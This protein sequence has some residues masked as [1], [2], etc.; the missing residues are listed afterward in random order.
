[1]IQINLTDTGVHAELARLVNAFDNPQPALKSIGELVVEF[2]K[3]RFEVSQ[4]PYGKPW[5]PN[6]DTTLRR[7]LHGNAKNF[8]KVKGRLSARGQLALSSKKPLIGESKSLSTQF[9]WRLVGDGVEIRSTMIYAAM[10]QF[11][12]KKA[13]FPNLWG[14]IPAR[15]F[16]PDAAR[17]L[18]T[19]LAHRIHQ[20]LADYI[21]GA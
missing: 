9:A 3:T 5:A 15:P 16:F 18:P 12:G 4:D 14:D 7:M 19:G 8:T 11:G 13:D 1:M 21:A 10:Q 17:G 2:T 6:T 20:V